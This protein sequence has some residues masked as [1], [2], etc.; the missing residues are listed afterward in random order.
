MKTQGSRQD[1]LRK[2]TTTVVSILVC[3]VLSISIF[4]ENW[5]WVDFFDTTRLL[6]FIRT[7]NDYTNALMGGNSQQ[8]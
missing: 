1:D 8:I 7:W 2:D 4:V 3:S 6:I 5:A